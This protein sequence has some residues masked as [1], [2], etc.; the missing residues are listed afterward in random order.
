MILSHAF[1]VVQNSSLRFI[2]CNDDYWWHS[3]DDIIF[4]MSITTVLDNPDLLNVSNGVRKDFRKLLIV[5]SDNKT[6][7]SMEKLM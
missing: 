4:K 5:T 1:Q 2:F 3:K 7:K 6:Y